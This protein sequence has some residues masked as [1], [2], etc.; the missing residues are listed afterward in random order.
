MRFDRG[1][2]VRRLRDLAE[3]KRAAFALALCERMLPNHRAFTRATGGGSDALRGGLDA[4]WARLVAGGAPADAE[5]WIARCAAAAPD[6]EA[7][8]HPLVSAAL[9]AAG[10]V[11]L[12]LRYLVDSDIDRDV[13]AASL[14]RDTVDMAVALPG[15]PGARAADREARALRDPLVQREL[16]RQRDD[17]D[18][19]A[20]LDGDAGSRIDELR[21]RWY[22]PASGSLGGSVR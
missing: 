11:E 18:W 10:A 7:H 2:L 8:D 1:A 9:D 5:A 15:V 3:W 12:L 16:R 17:L 22:D 19:L 20:A 14:A 4:A 6:T 13:E 21:A